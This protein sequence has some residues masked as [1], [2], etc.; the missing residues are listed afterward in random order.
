MTII[1]IIVCACTVIPFSLLF[2]W[3]WWNLVAGIISG[4]ST[5]IVI[6][7]IFEFP[8]KISHWGLT[9]KNFWWVPFAIRMP[10]MLNGRKDKREWCKENCN[11]SWDYHNFSFRFSASS[12]ALAFKIRYPEDND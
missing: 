2:S 4:Y 6:W 8:G 3:S 7:F 1:A 11:H 9:L 12:D 10:C 5:V